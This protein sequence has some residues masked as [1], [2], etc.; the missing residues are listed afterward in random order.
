MQVVMGFVIAVVG[1]IAVRSIYPREDDAFW[2]TG[3]V[4]AAIIYVVF[5]FFG[6]SV[7]WMLIEMG[8]VVLYFGLAVLAK[9]YSLLFLALGWVLHILWD[10]LL[11]AGGVPS[12]VPAWYPTLCLGFDLAIAGYVIWL[13][14]ERISKGKQKSLVDPAMKRTS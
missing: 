4:I 13:W 3:L 11:H 14:R 12:F 8:G 2:R 10:M 9:R 7:Q 5:S 1:I 6:G